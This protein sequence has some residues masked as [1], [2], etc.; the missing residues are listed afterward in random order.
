KPDP[1]PEEALNKNAGRMLSAGII[2]PFLWAANPIVGAGVHIFS[3]IHYRGALRSQKRKMAIAGVILCVAGLVL[4]PIDSI[5]MGRFKKPYANFYA[6][7]PGS[8]A[9]TI[10][11][12]GKESLELTSYVSTKGGFAM[13][14][15]KG[16]TPDENGT[17][18]SQFVFNGPEDGLVEGKPFRPQL[19]VDSAPAPSLDIKSTQDAVRML[20]KSLEEEHPGASLA[21]ERIMLA[22]GRL[23]AS[24]L[25]SAY[26]DNGADVH[27]LLMVVIKDGIMYFAGS[28][29]PPEKW[30]RN[31]ETVKDSLRTFHIRQK[32]YV[33]EK[34]KFSMSVP[35]HWIVVESGKPETPVA[36]RNALPDTAGGE[37][38][39]ANINVAVGPAQK[40]SVQDIYDTVEE[41][42]NALPKVFKN[43]S[44][45]EDEDHT[46]AGGQNMHF[47]GA[48]FTQ[49]GVVF[50]NLQLFAV[51]GNKLYVVTAT[52]PSEVWALYGQVIKDVFET[53]DI[54]GP[55][56]LGPFAD[57]IK[58][59]S[60][61][62]YGAFDCS[63]CQAQ[64]KLFG[65]A[66]SR[67][68]YVE[69]STPDGKYQ[70][71]V[72]SDRDIKAYP[73]WEFPDGSRQTGELPLETLSERTG[74]ALP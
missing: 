17:E 12:T 13:H 48:V 18:D 60:V 35:K 39:F 27:I 49:Q 44:I 61:V 31:A 24:F 47:L 56:N 37:P 53:F 63:H 4:M 54:V 38:F 68:P 25:D 2:A 26:K 41:V 14:Q 65:D 1:L 45:V 55:S 46:T 73:T 6:D 9:K 74:C 51:G 15:P 22:G 23:D 33:N 19:N 52:A 20:T 50:R 10:T 40:N 57:C 11:P 43:Y 59:K 5:G 69:C 64:K 42:K 8:L 72:C 71:G 32:T 29:M 66:A 36:F 16:W 28:K 70:T 62:F 67:L 30:T 34:E 7:G 3:L 21:E 58:S